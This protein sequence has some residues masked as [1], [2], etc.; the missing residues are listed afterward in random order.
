MGTNSTRVKAKSE[1]S[2]PQAPLWLTCFDGPED[3]SV[4]TKGTKPPRCHGREEDTPR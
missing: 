1:N 4:E 2:Q 3:L